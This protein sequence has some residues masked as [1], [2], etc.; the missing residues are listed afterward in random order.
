MIGPFERIRTSNSEL[1]QVQDA[2]DSVVRDIAS[3]QILDGRL[4]EDVKLEQGKVK[5]LPHNL[6]RELSGWLVVRKSANANIWDGQI[7]SPTPARTL[8]LHNSLSTLGST[9]T[10]SLWVF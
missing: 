1:R 9:M 3:R 8:T 6:G 7:S 2:T 10:V 5:V 4:I